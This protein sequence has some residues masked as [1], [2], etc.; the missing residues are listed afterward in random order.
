MAEPA[1]SVLPLALL[2]V[3]RRRH[4]HDPLPGLRADP[5]LVV[6]D[7]VGDAVGGHG[8]VGAAALPLAGLGARGPGRPRAPVAVDRAGLLV[9]RVD[10]GEIATVLVR[11]VA[12][13]KRLKPS[14]ER[15]LGWQVAQ[16]VPT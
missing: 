15:K 5:A 7:V 3:V 14:R 1:L 11:F 8:V 12:Y 2:S 9:A 10:L 4:L 16:F 6:V 13:R